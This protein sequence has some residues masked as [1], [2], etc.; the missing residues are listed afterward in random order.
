LEALSLNLEFWKFR[1]YLI[2]HLI[3]RGWVPQEYVSV[4]Q[5]PDLFTNNLKIVFSLIFIESWKLF[6]SCKP[7]IG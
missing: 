2:S 5:A 7:Q 3:R 4:Q 1:L 6:L